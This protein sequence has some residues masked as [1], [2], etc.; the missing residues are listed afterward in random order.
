MMAETNFLWAKFGGNRKWGNFWRFFFLIEHFAVSDLKRF[1]NVPGLFYFISIGLL[2]NTLKH[3][4]QNQPK[5]S[6]HEKLSGNELAWDHALSLLSLSVSHGKRA[7]FLSPSS[8]RSKEAKNKKINKITRD[9]RLVR[10]MNTYAI[11]SAWQQPL[12]CSHL[13]YRL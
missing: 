11:W 9:L 5:I 8:Q 7:L 1:K 10:S 4:K 3:G 2:N 13:V 12:L 6:R